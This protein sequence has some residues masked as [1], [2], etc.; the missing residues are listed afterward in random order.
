MPQA[1]AACSFEPSANTWRPNTVRESTVAVSA[2]SASMIHTPG[3]STI[4]AWRGNVTSRSFTQVGGTFTVCSCAIH[5]AMPRAMPSIPSVAMNGTT[6][7]PVISRPLP[8]PTSPPA[9]RAAAVATTGDHPAASPSAA[10]TPVRAIAAPT[11]RSIPPLIM[12]SVM[13]IAPRATITVCDRTIRRL[14]GE[15]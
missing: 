10:T 13:P 4:H 1:R 7:R 8:R 6:R 5:L 2:A 15:R 3:G 14:N 12:I 11:E 9:T